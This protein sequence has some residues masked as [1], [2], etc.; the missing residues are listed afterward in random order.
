MV[1]RC[2]GRACTTRMSRAEIP[3]PSEVP[4][5]TSHHLLTVDDPSKIEDKQMA[6]LAD[7]TVGRCSLPEAACHTGGLWGSQEAEPS[8]RAG[9]ATPTEVVDEAEAVGCSWASVEHEELGRRGGLELESTAP[10]PGQGTAWSADV[11]VHD[12][13]ADDAAEPDLALRFSCPHN[14]VHHSGTVVEI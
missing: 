8:L 10:C 3:K 5:K 1:W 4:W 13:S 14:P 7:H 6:I 11:A 12:A 2:Q 9:F